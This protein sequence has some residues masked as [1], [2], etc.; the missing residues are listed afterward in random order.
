MKR[1]VKQCLSIIP[2]I[3]TK[4][5]TTSSAQIIEHKNISTYA[6]GNPSPHLGHA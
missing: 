2:S 5:T 3:S 6:D 4:Q 1:N